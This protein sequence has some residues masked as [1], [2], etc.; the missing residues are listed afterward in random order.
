MNKKTTQITIRLEDEDAKTLEEMAI[1]KKRKRADLMRLIIQ[2]AI[3]EYRESKE[4][5]EKFQ[6]KDLIG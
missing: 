5:I 2:E 4:K 1:Q 6:R 3:E